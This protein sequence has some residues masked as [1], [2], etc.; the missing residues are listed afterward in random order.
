MTDADTILSL[1]TAATGTANGWTASRNQ[2]GRFVCPAI[3]PTPTSTARQT[4]IRNRMAYVIARWQTGLTAAQRT[5]WN[6]Y[7]ARVRRPD[8]LGEP[9]R[10]HGLE[11]Y[12]RCNL[13]RSQLIPDIQ[14]TPPVDDAV[15]STPRCTFRIVLTRFIVCRADV[16]PWPYTTP[17]ACMIFAAGPNVAAT[18]NKPKGRW[19]YHAGII[20]AFNPAPALQ[21]TAIS[22]WYPPGL[23][24]CFV[25][26]RFVNYDG[27]PAPWR[28]EV[29]TPTS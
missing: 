27:V 23:S 4:T 20:G 3:S 7:A 16:E 8:P 26:Y 29:A 28:W 9:I 2:H 15:P 22:P 25:R 10:L 5:A 21:V 1:T 17:R 13:S 18:R 24:R 11:A 14:D 12:V 6:A 19:R